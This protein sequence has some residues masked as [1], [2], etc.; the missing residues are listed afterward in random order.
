MKC[1]GQDTKYWKDDAIFEVNCPKCGTAIEFYKDDT[2]RKCGQCNHRLVNPKMDFGCASYCQFAEQCMGTLP[3]EFMGSREDLL[4]DKV[5]VAMK[6]FFKTDFK[7]IRKATSAARHAENIG[8]AEGGNLA[9]ILCGVYLYGTGLE[10]ARSILHQVGAS[11]PLVQEICQI[12]E[13]QA[14]LA[15]NAPSAAIIVH[16]AVM[17]QQL[18]DDLKKDRIA[19]ETAEQQIPQKL[20]TKSAR[21]I[22]ADFIK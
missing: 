12:L 7:S 22:A 10:N 9:V 14:E 8:K 11:E 16:D 21:T 4:K 3:E 13:T 19:V 15:P 6:R 17:L 20:F 18:E 1:P 2:T 5:A